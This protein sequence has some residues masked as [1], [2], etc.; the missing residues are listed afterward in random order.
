MEPAENRIAYIRFEKLTFSYPYSDFQVISDVS[1]ELEK[2]ELVLLVGPSGCGKV[3]L[4]AALTGWCLRYQGETF[5][6][7]SCSGEK[8]SR[9]KK[10]TGWLLK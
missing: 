1:L 6:G 10:S 4:S 5:S 3:L 9:M 2:G 7:A 8:T